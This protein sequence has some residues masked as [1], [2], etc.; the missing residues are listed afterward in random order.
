[1]PPKHGRNFIRFACKSRGPRNLCSFAKKSSRSHPGNRHAWTFLQLTAKDEPDPPDLLA[2]AKEI[3]RLHP[4]S[5]NAWAHLDAAYERH[6]EDDSG[7]ISFCKELIKRAL[8][9]SVRADA[10]QPGLQE[11]GQ[12]HRTDLRLFP[13]SDR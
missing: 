12:I 4:D 3:V 1:M 13:T 11:T 8:G 7:L 10:P 9:Q 5:D 6:E 2:F